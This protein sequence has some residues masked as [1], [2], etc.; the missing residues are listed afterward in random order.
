VALTAS[1]GSSHAGKMQWQA[2]DGGKPVTYDRDPDATMKR[3]LEVKILKLL[4]I[5][6][7]L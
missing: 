4:P 1:G 3:G 6:G 5:E 7:M 2:S